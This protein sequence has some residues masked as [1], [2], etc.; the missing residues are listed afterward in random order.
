V[1]EE[2]ANRADKKERDDNDDFSVH[3]ISDLVGTA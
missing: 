3:G 1:Q 2:T